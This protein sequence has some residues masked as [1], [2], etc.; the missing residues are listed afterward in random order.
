MHALFENS[1]GGCILVLRPVARVPFLTLR[2]CCGIGHEKMVTC[3]AVQTEQHLL[4]VVCLFRARI[5]SRGRADFCLQSSAGEEN[6]REARL[7]V[8]ASVS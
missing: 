7:V 3:S 2:L 8:V 6:D 4:L 1:E 5:S